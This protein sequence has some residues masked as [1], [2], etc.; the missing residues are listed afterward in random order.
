MPQ[1]FQRIHMPKPL[2]KEIETFILSPD[3]PYKT[4]AE[5]CRK[6]GEMLIE[7]NNLR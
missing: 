4:V 3:A 2:Y 1:K 6:A 5:L 7:Q